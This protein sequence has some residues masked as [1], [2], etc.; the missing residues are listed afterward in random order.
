MAQSTRDTTQNN[1]VAAGLTTGAIS[2]ALF[3][4]AMLN[5]E[6]A[7]HFAQAEP[8]YGEIARGRAATVVE[9]DALTQALRAS[10]VPADLSRAALVQMLTAQQVGLETIR[11]LPRLSAARRD[12]RLGLAAAP[13]DAFAWT[14]LAV[15]ETNLDNRQNAA[16]ALSLALQVAPTDQKLAALQFDLAVVVWPQLSSDAKALVERRLNWAQRW[17]SLKTVVEGNSAGALR[18]LIAADQADPF[19]DAVKQKPR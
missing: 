5:V 17:P 1:A 13:T 18:R 15:T 6:A 11:A 8:R 14:R 12:L 19:Q 10:P 9:L 3:V 4:Y 7:W 16:A 2:A